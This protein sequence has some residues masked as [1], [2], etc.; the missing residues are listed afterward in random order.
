MRV[1]IIIPCKFTRKYPRSLSRLEWQ[2]DSLQGLNAIVCDYGSDDREKIEGVC[3]QH[4]AEMVYV[5]YGEDYHGNSAR[6]IN[7]GIY[8]ATGADHVVVS[9]VDLV[10][11]PGFADKLRE[12][13]RPDKLMGFPVLDLPEG[14]NLYL[15][16]RFSVPRRFGPRYSCCPLLI[17]RLWL[18]SIGGY[19]QKYEGY[20]GLDN[21]I[22]K[23]AYLAGKRVEWTEYGYVY[24]VWHEDYKARPEFEKQRRKNRERLGQMESVRRNDGTG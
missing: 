15:A 2:L 19:D 4:G 23:R 17:P 3:R 22:V 5:Y 10:Y 1:S 7:Q 12:V 11:E 6:A 9:D 20:G 14:K 18:I 8:F 13:A 24:H 21:D 16:M